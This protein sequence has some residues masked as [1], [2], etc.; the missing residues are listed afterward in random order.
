MYEEATDFHNGFAAVRLNGKCGAVNQK[1]E[2][3]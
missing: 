1:G 3:V 2:P